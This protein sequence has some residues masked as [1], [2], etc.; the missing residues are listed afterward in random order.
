M[1]LKLAG[2]KLDLFDNEEMYTFIERSIR[3]GISLISKRFSKANNKH[4]P[5]YD[6]LKPISYLIYLDANNL[7]GWAMSQYIPT[8]NFRWLTE[9]EIENI[10]MHFLDDESETGYIFEVDLKYPQRLHDLHNSYP[11]APERLTI[12]ES[13]THS[14]RAI[15]KSLKETVDKTR[16][17]LAR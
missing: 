1:A 14:I 12:D 3:G 15:S 8:K 10:V 9:E 4:F 13:I 11:L 16:T 6:P 5:D 7:Y 2:V 17:E